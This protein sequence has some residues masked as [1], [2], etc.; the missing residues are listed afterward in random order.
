[1]AGEM[2]HRGRSCW[3]WT[4]SEWVETLGTTERE[5]RRR[6]RGQTDKRQHLITVAYLLADFT[7][8]IAIGEINR[9]GIA[10]KVFGQSRIDA[11]AERV[12][13]AALR[14]GY[15]PKVR[16]RLQ[17]ALCEALLANH[18]PRLEDL[19]AERFE[20]LR[21]G[22]GE[23]DQRGWFVLGQALFGLGLLPRAP[24]TAQRGTARQDAS[25]KDGGIGRLAQLVR[26]VAYDVDA[27]ADQPAQLLPHAVS[28]RAVAS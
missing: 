7:D 6:H 13:A 11:A 27:V 1:M 19:T 16:D 9:L 28:G 26:A 12:V 22:R 14:L 25:D 18:S 10:R 2:H 4:H 17:V 5:C 21:R 8:W 3:G 15:R 20:A 24:K 23:S